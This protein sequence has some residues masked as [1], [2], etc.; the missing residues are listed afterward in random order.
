M[1]SIDALDRDRIR[2][3]FDIRSPVFEFTG[4]GYAGDLHASFRELR[5]RAAVQEG[6]VHDLIG[7][8]GPAIFHGLPEPDRPHFSAFSFETIDQVYRNDTI[9]A[10]SPQAVDQPDAPV[11]HEASMLMMGGAPHRRYRNL[12]QPSFVPAKM[13]WWLDKWVDSS[14]N[15]LIDFFLDDG[16]AELNVDF[17]ASIP[18]LTITGSFGIAVDQALDVR[19]NLHDAEWMSDFLAPILAARREQPLD[20]LISVLVEA[21]LAGDDGSVHRLSDDEIHSFAVLLLLAGSGTT[22]KQM[23]IAIA[24]LL[25]RPELLEEVRADRSKIKPLIEESLRW[26]PTDPMFSRWVTE[27]TELGGVSI[28]KGAV[29]HMCLGAA[30]RDPARW[31]DPDEFDIHRQLKPSLGFGG[32]AHVCL[33]MHLARLEMTTG[34][35][36]LLDRLPGLRLDPDRPAPE[37]IGLYERAASEIPVVF[38]PPTENGGDQN[39]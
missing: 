24:T 37:L 39:G 38:D 36:A 3:L 17:C 25:T 23:G 29:M 32:G 15:M 12:V 18:V 4:G 10:S 7:H 13:H 31:D 11:G 20:D 9:Y 6:T 22:W 28:P 26:E 2:E 8:D 19:S 14:A 34:I 21:E 30:N 35:N 1:T 5:E 27:D 16:A 33:G